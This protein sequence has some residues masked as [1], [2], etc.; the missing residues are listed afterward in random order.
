M[1]DKLIAG[2]ATEN[3]LLQIIAKQAK[4]IEK[5]KADLRKLADRV[6]ALEP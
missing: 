1:G 2:T 4:E 5:L 3:N 6:T